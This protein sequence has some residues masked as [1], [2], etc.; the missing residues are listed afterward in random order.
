[1]LLKIGKMQLGNVRVL[2]KGIVGKF[3]NWPDD[4]SKV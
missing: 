4:A 1:M 3:G 2:D